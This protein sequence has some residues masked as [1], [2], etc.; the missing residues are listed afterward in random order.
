M[1][2]L[3]KSS[4]RDAWGVGAQS[5]PK[6]AEKHEFVNSSVQAVCQ[7][8]LTQSQ[9]GTEAQ[10]ALHSMEKLAILALMRACLCI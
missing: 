9:P 10:A 1:M 5:V 6:L 7:H 8:V 3:C 4:W 2:L